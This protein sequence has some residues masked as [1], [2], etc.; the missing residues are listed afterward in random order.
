MLRDGAEIYDPV[1]MSH[2]AA[3][4]AF[5]I[6]VLGVCSY[7]V[8][9]YLRRQIAMRRQDELLR[10]QIP[11]QHAIIDT[12]IAQLQ[13]ILQQVHQAELSID[14]GAHQASYILRDAFDKV[15]NHRTVFQS[16]D[17]VTARNLSGVSNS[18]S[19]AYPMEFDLKTAKATSAAEFGALIGIASE[20]LRACK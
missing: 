8:V 18:L 3:F 12:A 6:T 15:M 9:R 19:G 20:V 4:S 7:F 2:V 5:T 11:N 17:E 16:M 1:S 14:N 10:K 13:V